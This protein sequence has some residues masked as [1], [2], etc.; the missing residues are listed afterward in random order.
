MQLALDR[1]ALAVAAGAEAARAVA[2]VV[3]WRAAEMPVEIGAGGEPS[4]PRPMRVCLRKRPLSGA[5]AAALGT[6]DDRAEKCFDAV[7]VASPCA[8]F[9]DWRDSNDV[10]SRAGGM[11]T[12]TY[13][14]FDRAFGEADDTDRVYATAVRDLVPFVLSGG[15]ATCIAYG[16][17][18]AG[19]TYT[20]T[21]LQ[22]RLARDVFAAA[23]GRAVRLAFLENQGERCFDLQNERAKVPLREDA[24][25]SDHVAGLT[26]VTVSTL[27]DL[28]GA[29]AAANQLR[30]TAPTQTHPHSSRSHAILTLR[31][32]GSDGLLR[33]VDLAGSERH[34][35]ASAHS[36]ERIAEMKDIN[37]SLSSLKD[38]IRAQRDAPATAAA[39]S[40]VHVPYRRSKLTM[41]LKECF[42][43]PDARTIFFGHVSP[44]AACT[45]YTKSTLDYCTQL[46][47]VAELRAN[48]R[49]SSIGGAKGPTDPSKWSRARVRKWLETV[50][51]GRFAFAVDDIPL[52]GMT[53]RHTPTSGEF[54]FDTRLGLAG[55]ADEDKL[56]EGQRLGDLFSKVLQAFA[57]HSKARPSAKSTAN[58]NRQ[59]T[60]ASAI[61]AHVMGELMAYYK[62]FNPKFANPLKISR[63]CRSFQSK[64]AA[65]QAVQGQ[66]VWYYA[67]AR[68][69]PVLA[70]HYSASREGS[71]S[72]QA[73]A[74]EAW[75][76]L[77]YGALKEKT[78]GVGPREVPQ[79][80]ASC[81]YVP[82]ET[83]SA[84]VAVPLQEINQA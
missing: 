7:S 82:V 44:L 52:D 12:K 53:M 57:E 19:K 38:C 59:K 72:A 43:A 49:G 54:G 24:A 40:Q 46:L 58:P 69:E 26:E 10:M 48:P 77:L 41:L 81:G 36:M 21:G 78:G 11:A 20:M 17:T 76:G 75:V 2:A 18:G 5:E 60:A 50:D 70:Q 73:A 8:F 51:G 27:E 4:A 56:A 80:A 6:A 33:V 9:H 68:D 13:G 28:R 15:T 30:A 22:D 45:Q 64:T 79:P 34:E 65:T 74:E 66:V 71:C 67:S 25:G 39:G 84:S 61:S 62:Q 29:L 1:D 31:V 14:P 16:Q 32:E 47:A 55:V 83:T 23:D 35:S 3:S 37:S 42:T 63:I